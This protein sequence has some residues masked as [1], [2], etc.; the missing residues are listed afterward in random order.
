M[1]DQERL[2]IVNKKSEEESQARASADAAAALDTLA[3]ADFRA[4]ISAP[5]M[6]A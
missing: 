2:I 6:A 4:R 1:A 3:A 5:L